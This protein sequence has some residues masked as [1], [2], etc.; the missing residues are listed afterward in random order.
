ML[1]FIVFTMCFA[2][3]G[4]V[5]KYVIR[6]ESCGIPLSHIKL[7]LEKVH[8]CCAWLHSSRA[9]RLHGLRLQYIHPQIEGVVASASL[10]IHMIDHVGLNA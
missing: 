6:S 1:Q 4:S 3:A 9:I 10:E 2:V 5:V 7:Q 8:T